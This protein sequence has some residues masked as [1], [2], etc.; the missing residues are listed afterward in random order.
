MYSIRKKL[1]DGSGEAADLNIGKGIINNFS[2]YAEA[3]ERYSLANSSC[4]RRRS[5]IP[6][7]FQRSQGPNTALATNFDSTDQ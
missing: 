6:G 3:S 2:E 1:S 5:G 7:L 4:R